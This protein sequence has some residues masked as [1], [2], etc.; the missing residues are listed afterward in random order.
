MA[1]DPVLSPLVSAL[2]LIAPSGVRPRRRPSYYIKK[3]TA[4][5]LK[6]PF[7]LLPGRLQA[8]GL[9]WLR[10]SL[11]WK[12]LGSSDYRRLDGV[13]RETFVKTVTHYL[14]DRLH[15]V[16]VPTLI[17]W[18][19]RDS[20]IR[21]E[22]ISRLESQIPDAGVVVLERAGHYAHLDDP[23]TV[24]LATRHFLSTVRAGGDAT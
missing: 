24:L 16:Q 6:A 23:Q 13:M 7:N 1:S 2:V 11:V 9:D 15:Q 10:H 4:Q 8:F 21:R 18:G 5:L 22:Q 3:F 14:E 17:F 12:A 20:D 19:D